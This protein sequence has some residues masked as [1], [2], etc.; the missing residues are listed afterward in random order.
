MFNLFNYT[1]CDQLQ[2][3]KKINNFKT[4]KYVDIKNNTSL[5][6]IFFYFH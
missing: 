1:N 2:R 4:K 6:Y 3:C 5:E